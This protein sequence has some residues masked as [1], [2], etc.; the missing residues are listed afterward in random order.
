MTGTVAT[1]ARA[2]TD[3]DSA[4]RPRWRTF[5]GSD[6][7]LAAAVALGFVVVVVAL[8]ALPG[9]RVTGSVP[10]TITAPTVGAELWPGTTLV[11]PVRASDDRLAAIYGTFG[12]WGGQAQCELDVSLRETGTGSPVAQRVVTCEE[13]TDGGHVL[14]LDVPPVADSAGRD[15]DVVIERLDDAGELPPV[16]W[17]GEPRGAAQQA[18]LNGAPVEGATTLRPEYD[19]Q[20]RRWDHLGRTLDRLG[21]YGPAWGAPAAVVGL[22]GL[23]GVLLAVVPVALRRP[24]ALLLVVAGLALARGLVW[25]AAVPPLEGMDE[26]AHVAYVQFLAEE[27]AFP[28]HVDNHDVFSDRLDAA[29]EVT[30]Q[31]AM[32]PGNRP[33]YTPEHEATVTQE[34]RALSP[35][36]GGGGPGTMY[37]PFFYLGGVPLYEAG[38][39]DIFTQIGL[40]RLWSV[41]LGVLSAVLLLVIGR[42][43]FPGSRVAVAAFAVAGVLQPMVAHQ[44][45][46]VNNDAWVISTGFAA[47]AVGLELARRS[48]APGLAL[49]AGIVLGAALLGKPFAIATAVPLGVGWLVGKIRTRERSWRALVGEPVLV[50]AGVLATYGAWSVV[51]ARL[52]LATS[53]VPE[54]TATGQTF[55]GFARR[56]LSPDALHA[57]WGHQ[58]W[59]NF[60]WVR[61]P[62][63]P[64][65]P[66]VLALVV[67]GVVLGCA[68]WAV[69]ALGAALRRARQRR[70]TGAVT[71]APAADDVARAPLPLD[72][73]L[74]L[75]TATVA[76]TMLTLYAAGWLYYASTGRTDLLQGRYALLAVPALLAAPALLVERFSRGRVGAAPVAVLTAVGM[77]AANLVGLLVMTEAFYG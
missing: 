22:L 17:A 42:Q 13:L 48:R 32:P 30:N 50:V 53:A 46:I 59:G 9:G 44:F 67:V 51:A 7:G 6:R 71:H 60:G 64:P 12:T 72:V 52:Q 40:V 3:D 34:L 66:T 1:G 49:L 31:D 15:Y 73:R 39:D 2:E 14:L 26:P 56:Q 61:I 11:Q 35:E 76:G 5:L 18:Q 63:P 65:V 23:M 54:Q 75:V 8:L 19:P 55:L 69:Q 25:S 29:I 36:G 77:V 20:P 24:R 70:A 41:A 27:R 58:L 43:L 16:L 21:A 4:G 37:A 45:A 38:G 10:V 47:L 28:G 57:M 33:P 62:M 68:V 74:V